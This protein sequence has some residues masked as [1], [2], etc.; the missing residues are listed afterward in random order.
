MWENV[1]RGTLWPAIPLIPLF[2]K[3]GMARLQ[4]LN[5]Q[6][7]KRKRTQSEP[8][9]SS[10]HHCTKWFFRKHRCAPKRKKQPITA[11]LTC[12]PLFFFL[13]VHSFIP[14][15]I[16]PPHHCPPLPV[17]LLLSRAVQGSC[18]WL[19]QLKMHCCTKLWSPPVD[20]HR[21]RMQLIIATQ[22][23]RREVFLFRIRLGLVV[24]VV[25]LCFL[26]LS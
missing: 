4:R 14:L 3:S 7:E 24:E 26:S 13:S 9:M 10:P 12:T 25:F 23:C 19:V 22:V 5:A 20:P 6:M 17:L 18:S 16:S 15:T 21:L 8:E 11:C 2:T 1:K